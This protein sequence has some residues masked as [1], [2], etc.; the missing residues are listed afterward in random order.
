MIYH[1]FPKKT[2]E[3][4]GSEGEHECK[5]MPVT[6]GLLALLGVMAIMP[7]VPFL[8]SYRPLSA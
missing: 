8:G 4:D 6:N 3:I 7:V 2:M 1:D 5:S